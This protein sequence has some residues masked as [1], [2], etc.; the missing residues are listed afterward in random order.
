MSKKNSKKNAPPPPDPL[1]RAMRPFA[2][3]P[4]QILTIAVVVGGLIGI[5]LA[6]QFRWTGIQSFFATLVI[7]LACV[8]VAVWVYTLITGRGKPPETQSPPKVKKSK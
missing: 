4:R 6:Q 8:L 1:A 7:A 2:K 5:F 3:V